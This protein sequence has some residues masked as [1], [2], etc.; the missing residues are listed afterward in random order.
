[1]PVTPENKESLLDPE[2]SRGTLAADRT[3]IHIIPWQAWDGIERAERI[4]QLRQLVD[5]IFRERMM[6]GLALLLIPILILSDFARLPAIFMSI[7]AILD[8]AIWLFFILEYASRLIVAENQWGY[9]TSPLAIIYLAILAAPAV[10]LIMGGG[11]DIAR[12]FLVLRAMQS[13]LILF[14]SVKTVSRY[15]KPP[16]I[17]EV[18]SVAGMRVRSLLLAGPATDAALPEWR[19]VNIRNTTTGIDHKD[20]WIDF[21]GWTPADI[22]L[23]SRISNIPSDNL[24][25]NLRHLA[26]T[27]A[28]TSGRFTTVFV[29]IP[30]G[31]QEP[32]TGSTWQIFWDDLLVVYDQNSVMTFSKSK[33]PVL[34][35][36]VNDGRSEGIVISGPGIIYLIVRDE[37]DIIEDLILT[38]EEQ[39]AYLEMQPINRFP[40]NFLAMIY[41]DQKALGRI[42]SALQHTGTALEVCCDKI[43]DVAGA[44]SPE[45]TRLRSLIDRCTHLSD[46]AR[47]TLDSFAWMVNFY[48]NTTSFSLNRVMKILAVLTALTVVPVI[49]GGLLGMNLIDVPYSVSLLQVVTI[50]AIMMV[51]LSWVFFNLGWLRRS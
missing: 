30:Q 9:V 1:M 20:Q 35:R 50:V 3:S 15:L 11:Y 42:L 27:R 13:V 7:L 14:L 31:V 47:H 24:D 37:L 29:K 4:V 17:E 10:A 25:V 33:L 26:Y 49:V 40:S 45:E 23:I 22:P 44:D 12:Y 48:L 34:D 8:V 21:S 41:T 38:A 5:D 39:L 2:G 51:V 32:G 18:K 43:H 36:V 6:G 16:V 46:N 19:P 28:G